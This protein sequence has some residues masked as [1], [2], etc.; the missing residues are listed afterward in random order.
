[1]SGSTGLKAPGQIQGWKVKELNRNNNVVVG[2]MLTSQSMYTIFPKLKTDRVIN[3]ALDKASMMR[4]NILGQKSEMFTFFNQ[5]IQRVDSKNALN[6]KVEVELPAQENFIEVKK[7]HVSGDVETVGGQQSPWKMTVSTNLSP[8]NMYQLLDYPDIQFKPIDNGINEGTLGYTHEF[9]VIGNYNDFI[10]LKKLK[11]GSRFMNIGSPRGEAAKVRGMVNMTLGGAAYVCYKYPFTKMGFQTIVT[12]EAWR[13]GTHFGVVNGS[14]DQP[15]NYKIMFSF[16]EFD[17]KFKNESEMVYDRYLTVG[18]GFPPGEGYSMDKYTHLAHQLGPTWMDFFRAANK[19]FYYVSNF[20]IEYIFD[21][22]RRQIQKM[23]I[24]DRSG[25]V[26]DVI[27]GDGGWTLLNPELDRLDKQG[28]IDP[29]WIYGQTSALDKN[30]KGVI[31]NKKQIRG[32]YLDDYGTVIFHN[33]NIL[34][35]GLLSG[36]RDVRKGFKL[37]SYWFIIMISHNNDRQN[38][39]NKAIQLYENKD[40]EQFTPLVDEFTPTGPVGRT[41][42]NYK[43]SG[44]HLGRAY[45]I[46]NDL[47]K[48]IYVPNIQGMHILYSDLVIND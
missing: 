28:V 8:N 27:T 12:D 44:E 31:L 10:K 23:K 13:L 1:M 30:R 26:V 37:S 48:A 17:A 14:E 29:E 24:E 4:P 32:V 18:K 20:N 2:E 33:N 21:R 45:K 9:K 35:N 47:E 3:E 41:T 7:V 22:I 19:E 11:P 43:S 25:M 46:I 15:Q 40:M 36:Q 16:S 38:P 42:I 6:V 5:R 39:V 34:N